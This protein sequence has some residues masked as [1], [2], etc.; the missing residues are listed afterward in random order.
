MKKSIKA[1][2]N[3]SRISPTNISLEN[4]SKNATFVRRKELH[5]KSF[6]FEAFKPI[7]LS[8]KISGLHYE[9]SESTGNC[10]YN[11]QRIYCCIVLVMAIGLVSVTLFILK[12]VTKVDIH[13]FMPLMSILTS[14]LNALNVLCLI[15]ASQNKKAFRKIYICF[16]NLQTN[17]GSFVC[18]IYLKRIILIACFLCWISICLGTMFFVYYILIDNGQSLFQI[19]SFSL[20][21]GVAYANI[22]IGVFIVFILFFSITSWVFIACISLLFGIIL[23]KEFALFA[24]YIKIKFSKGI[25]LEEDLENER[26]QLLELIRLVKAVDCSLSL[27]QVACF[28]CNVANIC[29]AVYAVC[30]YSDIIRQNNTF[31]FYV[32]GLLACSL[33]L[34]VV[35]CS[36]ILIQNGVSMHSIM[37][38]API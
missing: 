23:H 4:D 17:S 21:K 7:R 20:I 1:S 6:F 31:N 35:C 37:A 11:L 27:R 14:T 2:P 36:G 19:I 10:C 33:D 22:W 12:S 32:F 25:Q 28:G 13:L 38:Y 30:Y 34:A 16:A 24:K 3:V 15:F 29:L 18:R 5:A 9:S 26:Q 8:L